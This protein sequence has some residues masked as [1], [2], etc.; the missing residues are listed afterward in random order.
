MNIQEVNKKKLRLIA[1]Y[2]VYWIA[3]LIT[4]V[5]L[6]GRQVVAPYG[7]FRVGVVAKM[8]AEM[9]SASSDTG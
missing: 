2:T 8:V 9:Y 7:I 5:I 3:K 4:K 6:A 1:Y